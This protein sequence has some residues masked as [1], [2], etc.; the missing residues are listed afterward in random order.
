MRGPEL[1]LRR[2]RE[3]SNESL[4]RALWV[5]AAQMHGQ[6]LD[7]RLQ[8]AGQPRQG[9]P[10]P[11][12]L[13]WGPA[14]SL[15]LPV[16]DAFQQ[17]PRRRLNQAVGSLVLRVVGALKGPH[18]RC[19][20]APDSIQIGFEPGVSGR[21]FASV[22]DCGYVLR[23]H[24]ERQGLNV[25]QQFSDRFCRQAYISQPPPHFLGR[26]VIAWHTGAV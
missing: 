13:S 23:P 7:P 6:L 21:I 9:P 1:R 17:P 8:L 14:S 24:S 3:V 26:A 20:A 10:F 16:F 4:K 2:T 15:S 12:D 18:L 5:A 22:N 19:F 25:G 11:L